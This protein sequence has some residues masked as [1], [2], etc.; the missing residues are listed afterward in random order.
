MGKGKFSFGINTMLPIHQKSFGRQCRGAIPLVGQFE[1][2]FVNFVYI[3][4]ITKT[5]QNMETLENSNPKPLSVKEWLKTLLLLAIPVVGNCF[6]FFVYA[7]RQ[8]RK[9]QNRQNLGKKPI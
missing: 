2:R 4:F 8:Q 5:K 1:L 3:S 6:T 9:I 7:F